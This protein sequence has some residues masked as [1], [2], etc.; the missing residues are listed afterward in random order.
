M[1]DR[2]TGEY[3]ALL[4][5]LTLSLMAFAAC[6]WLGYQ[7][8]RLL[9]QDAP[10]GAMDLRQ[11]FDEVQQWFAG[12]EVYGAM[13]TATYPPASYVLLWPLMGWLDFTTARWLWAATA[14]A[15]LCWLIRLFLAASGAQTSLERTFVTL[16]PLCVYGTGATIGNGQL[17]VHLLP[18]LVAGLLCANQQPRAWKATALASVPLTFALVKPSVAAPFFW[19][20]CFVPG[21]VRP[22][23]F[24]GVGYIGLSLLASAFQPEPILELIRGW[25]STSA[26]FLNTNTGRHS[27]GNLHSLLFWLG[28]VQW[29]SALSLAML[30]AFGAWV[31]RFRNASIWVLMGVAALVSRFY[32][33][34]AWYDDVLVLLPFM[35]LLRLVKEKSLLPRW[36]FAAEVLLVGTFLSMVAP[37][38]TYLFP[39][40]WNHVYVFL[41][42]GIWLV[43]LTFLIAH[44]R[45]VDGAQ[46]DLTV[47]P[48]ARRAFGR[49]VRNN[50]KRPSVPVG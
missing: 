47:P 14:I 25:L 24:V 48:G 5:R 19:L 34:H 30:L 40:P 39:E 9:F 35:A 37:G 28:K 46:E 6:V 27:H 23:L 7:F 1:R 22:A 15:A 11:R 42:T 21:S 41:Q 12:E 26:H 43:L 20:V 4:A 13:R 2:T 10:L 29:L 38:G 45:H 44:A 18:F 3:G 16:L 8:W 36:H 33:Y 32:T 31:Y 49:E 50:C 17:G